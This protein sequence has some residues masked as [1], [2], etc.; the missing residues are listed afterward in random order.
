MIKKS[1]INFRPGKGLTDITKTM[2]V[3]TRDGDAKY[4]VVRVGW[5]LLMEGLKRIRWDRITKY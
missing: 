1:H 3:I 4:A 2:A 5:L